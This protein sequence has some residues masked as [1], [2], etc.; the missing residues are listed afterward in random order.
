[1]FEIRNLTFDDSKE[2][3]NIWNDEVGFIF[4]ISESLFNQSVYESKYYY[5]KGSFV[6]VV[7]NRIVGFVITK[8]YDNDPI[9]PKY[10][11]KG[12]I[13][14]WYVSNKY[15]K[16][17]IGK[18]LLLKGEEM[19]L[20]AGVKSISIGGDLDNFFPGIPC[21]FDNLTSSVVEKMGYNCG[22]Y[23]HDLLLTDFSK[24]KYCKNAD[25]EIR[26]ATANDKGE[27]LKF[28]KRYFP[29]RWENEA[30]VYFEE[31]DI[32]E[33]YLLA[34]QNE[35]IVGFLRVNDKRIKRISYNINWQNRFT[36]LAG[37]GPLGVANEKRG[38]GIAKELMMYA[39]VDLMNKGI[40]EIMIDWT[41]LMAIYQKYGFEVWKCY[42]YCSKDII[43]GGII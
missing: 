27:L 26:Y 3:L 5:S 6:A 16:R 43:N 38:N 35:T 4:P 40:K 30:R 34:T 20:A 2:I 21:D 14:I 42:Q 37:L 23:T 22:R 19:L 29:G 18:T 39:I 25:V 17:G 41:G 28:M 24:V 12:W 7:D 8:L 1:M 11:N 36:D 33:E 10:F 9:M 31:N 13:S 15:R 32:K